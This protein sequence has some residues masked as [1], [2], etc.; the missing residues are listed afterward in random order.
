M[1][2]TDEKLTPDIIFKGE[3]KEPFFYNINLEAKNVS[4]IFENLKK[5]FLHGLKVKYGEG[6]IIDLGSIDANKV[7]YINEYMLSIG[8][9][10]NYMIID[11]EQKD[12]LYR[13]LLHDLKKAD[14]IKNIDLNVTVDWKTELIKN[15]NIHINGGNTDIITKEVK[16]ITKKHPF[17]NY[18]LKIYPPHNLYDYALLVNFSGKE[19]IVHVINFEF[20][21]SL[22]YCKPITSISG[23]WQG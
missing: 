4:E 6:D 3:P 14:N 20:A 11:T 5:I 17:S 21:K 18:F 1:M 13:N 23:P 8:I 9:K 2:V 19:E 15:I 12:S 22:Q 16:E 10:V 7:N